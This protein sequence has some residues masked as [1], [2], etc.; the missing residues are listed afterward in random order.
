MRQGRAVRGN[1]SETRTGGNGGKLI[2][3]ENRPPAP[4][5]PTFGR[6]RGM[7]IARY[8]FG[9]MAWLMGLAG[10]LLLPDWSPW[11]RAGLVLAW[12]AGSIAAVYFG[13]E[14]ARCWILLGAGVLAFVPYAGIT[15]RNERD[16]A[17]ELTRAPAIEFRGDMVTIH[18]FR[19]ATYRSVDDFDLAWREITVDLAAIRTVDYVVEPF[20]A[21][22]GLAH[23]FLTFGF[24]DGRHVAI[25][26]ETRR[27]RGESYSPLKGLLRHYELI[28]VIGEERDLIG[29]RANIRRDP[30]H[31]YPIDTPPELVRA[32]FVSMLERAN[33]L[34]THPEFYNSYSDTCAAAVLRHVNAVRT[35]KISGGWRVLFPGFSDKFAWE[36]G[37]VDFDGTLE[38]ARARFLINE[39]SA[40]DPALDDPGWS[41]QIRTLP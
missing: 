22:R 10:L 28:Y 6:M 14:R 9:V 38:E 23:A 25:S 37:L 11:A 26:V 40:F 27:E 30:V 24:A 31:L 34:V 2:A 7:R 41:R 4:G 20:S 1:T 12:C 19:A 29:L 16:W 36:I 17:P 3:K 15:A 33:Q 35:D 32:L 5:P 8:T 21:W 18:N 13:A 39:R